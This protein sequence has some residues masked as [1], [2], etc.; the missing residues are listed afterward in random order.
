MFNYTLALENEMCFSGGNGHSATTFH[1]EQTTS[2]IKAPK[3]FWRI[4]T[5]L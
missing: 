5:L 2:S 1:C 3:H 4:L